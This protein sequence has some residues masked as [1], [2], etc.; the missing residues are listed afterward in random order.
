MAEYATRLA[1][2]QDTIDR[3]RRTDALGLTPSG[4][5]TL[6]RSGLRPD[7]GGA[8]TVNSGQMSVSVSAF[9]A[10]IDGTASDGQVGYPVFLDA[11]KTLSIAA[12]HAT[13]VRV[14][15]VVAQVRDTA[16]DGSGS[17]DFRVLVVQGTPGAGAPALPASAI[18]LRDISV[19]AGASAGT[20]GLTAANL[21]TDRRQYVT[22]LGGV[23]PVASSTE[24]DALSPKVRGMTVHRADT[25]RLEVYNGT[26]WV[27]YAPA[28]SVPLMRVGTVT[29]S[30]GGLA[31]GAQA[32]VTATFSTP[33][34]TGV[35]PT[36]TA[37]G[38]GFVSGSAPVVVRAVDTIS[39]S[40]C[41]IVLV[42]TSTS[43][44]TFTNLPL[45]YIA[46]A[47]PI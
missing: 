25:D 24:R 42:N 34:P 39:E 47:M 9:S 43:S 33:F 35:V 10:W 13:L 3:M 45:Q 2:S 32:T 41:R 8:V 44:A 36:V 4:N 5:P 30:S 15:T 20:G 38:A 16:Y 37:T 6:A 29:I 19:H 7:G 23:L 18:P 12:G 27:P 31:A 14:D 26:T 40:S 28:S 1:N 22:A 21:S 46:L 17:T 11:A